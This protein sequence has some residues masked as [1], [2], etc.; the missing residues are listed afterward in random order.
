MFKLKG[1]IYEINPIEVRTTASGKEF[2]RR[3]VILEIDGPRG[4]TTKLALEVDEYRM[5]ALEGFHPGDRVEV[6]FNVWSRE[7]ND[8][9]YTSVDLLYISDLAPAAPAPAPAP[10]DEEDLPDFLKV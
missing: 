10:E 1:V 6:K 3:K 4:T 9:W 7:W 8:K 5:E 2:K